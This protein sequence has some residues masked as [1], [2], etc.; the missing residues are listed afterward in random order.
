MERSLTARLARPL[1]IALPR[2]ASRR[3]SRAGI[4]LLDWARDAVTSLWGHRRTRLALLAVIVALPLLGG[5][6]LL[7]RNSS[8]VAVEHVH[9]SGVH[10][11]E[12]TAIDAA[13][14]AASHHMSTLNVN[15]GA[16]AAAVAQYPVV[17]GVRAVASFPHGLRIEVSEELPV[18]ALSANGQRTAVA[19]NGVALGPALATSSLPAINGWV[20]PAVGQR[21][22]SSTLLEALAVLGAAPQALARRVAHVYNG[23]EGLTL[24]MKNGLLAYFGN[25]V[26]P[27]AKWLSLARVLADHSST[28]AS[29]V[30]VRVPDRAAAGFPA[31]TTP[32]DAS[33]SSEAGSSSES[34]VGALAEGLT[35]ETGASSTAPATSSTSSTGTSEPES[36]SE[37]S[38]EAAHT[39][40][41]SGQETSPEASTPGG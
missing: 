7:L 32:P 31:G 4:G 2:P 35:K 13:L 28:G 5:G 37:P 15:A 38:S 39:E 24:E 19:A 6:Y 29:Y 41:S 27:H 33:T 30:D 10:G 18:A 22:H 12:A 34:T 1:G 25:G 36:S 16:L 40:S 8:F 23:P 20:V 9:V 21:L 3:A 14:I 11:A 17:S 26:R